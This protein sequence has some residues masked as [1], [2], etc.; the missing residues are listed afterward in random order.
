MSLSL[1][2]G[3]RGRP[4]PLKIT[5]G[6]TLRN[7]VRDDTRILISVDDDDPATINALDALPKDERIKVSIRPREDNRGEKSDR[8]LTEAPADVYMIGSDSV[9]ILTKGYDQLVLD[10][11]KLFPDG[12][13]VICTQMQNAS[14]PSF[15]AVTQKWVDLIGHIYCHD[16]PFWF[17]DHELDDL[18]R[19]TGRIVFVD[20]ADN[21]IPM[22]PTKTNRLRDLHFWC[23]Y[24]DCATF[25]R[26]ASAFR[27]IDQLDCPDYH[28][29]MLR[30]WYHP[31]EARS[32]YLNHCARRDAAEIEAAR[33]EPGEPDPGY[34]RAF[35][36]ARQTLKV[37]TRE[38]QALRQE[39]A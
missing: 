15:Q 11:A 35:D 31:V 37:M 23:D 25:R 13:G 18:A 29:A 19:M 16:Y 3:T 33:G 12:V 6:E 34:L 4:E 26:R 38:I 10:A 14:F 20:V 22:R 30:T 17:I 8:V 2:I 5:I 32:L 9:P 36:K 27:I 21:A 7:T 1:N 28:K 39:A 24:F